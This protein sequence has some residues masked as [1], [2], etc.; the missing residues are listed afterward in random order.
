MGEREVS[1]GEQQRFSDAMTRREARHTYLEV[2]GQAYA[3]EEEPS[4][5]ALLELSR[6]LRE[7]AKAPVRGSMATKARLA[8]ALSLGSLQTLEEQCEALRFVEA[9]LNIFH[10]GLGREAR[11]AR[12]AAEKARTEL[13][14]LMDALRDRAPEHL[15]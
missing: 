15:R 12:E 8:W 10:A 7:L 14:A 1:D 9:V 11:P 5:A 13:H 3:E 2:G 4:R 6:L